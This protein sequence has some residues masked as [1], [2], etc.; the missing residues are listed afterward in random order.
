MPPLRLG[1]LASGLDTEAV[2]AQLLSA[3]RAPR[4][5][6]ERQVDVVEARK[7][8][9]AD[10]ASRLRALKTAVA[11]LRSPTLFTDTQTV[12]TSDATRVGVARTGGVG[13]GA[14]AVKVHAVAA[15]EQQRYTY[16]AQ[17]GQTT[18]SLGGHSTTIAANA[19]IDD[20]VTAI[21]ADKDAKVWASKT[22][23]NEL[24]F[25]WRDT[26]DV[27]DGVRVTGDALTYAGMVR[28]GRNAD[29]E[30]DGVRNTTSTSNTI[31][32]LPGLT[33]TLKAPTA[34]DVQITVGPPGPDQSKIKDKVKAFVEAYNAAND[35]M[36]TELR[37]DKVR[38]AAN[39]VDRGKGALRGDP[40]IQTLQSQLRQ[41]LQTVVGSTAAADQ[42]AD[43]G[44]TTGS[45]TGA[46][47]FSADAVNGKL[48][49]DEAKLTETLA[50][51]PTA[52]KELLGGT[53]AGVAQALESILE[54]AVG[55][56]GTFAERAKSADAELTR[57][58]ASMSA[59]DE[60]LELRE[61]NLRAMFTRLEA[62]LAQSQSQGSQLGAQLARL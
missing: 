62:S 3:E 58:R 23:A 6:Y 53:G 11:D 16:A 56:D 30:I 2:L 17:A 60:R 25:S 9:L 51:N 10:I 13:T 59:F 48:V 35:L 52:V 46:G 26:G 49:L 41:A 29:F 50:A 24:V 54:Q 42:L 61:K 15:A 37:E 7:S 43:L 31:T 14:Y 19:T 8:T 4:S 38:N 1:G 27:A 40:A 22:A 34:A 21:N 36:R 55:T 44:I 12:E 28:E 39:R 32:S 20:A 45:S 33:L 47:T 57:L 18:I 5:R